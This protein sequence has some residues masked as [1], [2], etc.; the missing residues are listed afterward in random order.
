MKILRKI[1]HKLYR[2]YLS[3]VDPE[4]L[5]GKEDLNKH[6]INDARQGNLKCVELHLD[7]GA[8]IHAKDDAA[9]RQAAYSGHADVVQYLIE[10]GA[11]IEALDGYAIRKATLYGHLDTIKVLVKHGAD[12]NASKGSS[13]IS[14]TENGSLEIVEYLVDHGADVY[15]RNG[16][17]LLIAAR[18]GYLDIVRFFLEHDWYHWDFVHSN[19][20][21]ALDAAEHSHIISYIQA[22]RSDYHIN[23]K[24]LIKEL[25]H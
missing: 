6:L 12:V 18:C 23:K 2:W 20:D 19:L 3:K 25:Q 15:A 13:L 14:A 17:A 10:Q 7:R 22:L 24:Y 11:D 9:L 8:Y 21:E 16:H 4:A 5:E 1:R